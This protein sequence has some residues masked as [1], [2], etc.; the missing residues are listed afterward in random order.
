MSKFAPKSALLVAEIGKLALKQKE[1]NEDA[2]EIWP[3]R[4][5]T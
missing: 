3:H 2:E 4:H 1:E 5:S